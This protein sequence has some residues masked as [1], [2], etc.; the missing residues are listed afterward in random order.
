[1]RVAALF[2]GGKDSTYAAH[3]AAQRGWEVAHLVTVRPQDPESYMFHVPNLHLTP[4]LAEAMG[5]PL[6]TVEA[7]SGEARELAALQDALAALDVDGIVAGAV[8]SDYQRSRLNRIGHALGLPV[9]VPLW[10]LPAETL[11]RDYLHA[12]L[13]VLVVG[14]FAE[15]LGEE[16]L[17]R[18]LD[19]TAVEDLMTLSR[20]HRIHPLGE[21]GEYESLVV[22][23]PWF[24]RRLEVIRMEPVW[25]GTSGHVRVDARLA[26]RAPT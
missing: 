3:V 7:E 13:E 25:E 5:I 6:T 22:N 15:G 11:L 14:V 26:D 16:W 17:G 12:R 19:D 4:L 20:S 24:S 10:R 21:G 8:A 18:P 23:A 9:H 1:M 2:S